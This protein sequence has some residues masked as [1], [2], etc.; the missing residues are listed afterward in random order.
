MGWYSSLGP[1][2]LALHRCRNPG[3]TNLENLDLGLGGWE[4]KHSFLAMLPT[5]CNLIQYKIKN[6][7]YTNQLNM[8]TKH[9]H[10]YPE[11]PRSELA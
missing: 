2:A 7:T 4:N 11:S 9:D 5:I 8:A 10:L 1:C 6:A 3:V